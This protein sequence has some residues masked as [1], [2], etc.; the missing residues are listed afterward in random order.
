MNKIKRYFGFGLGLP[1]L[2]Y[3]GPAYNSYGFGKV[4]KTTWDP[5][6]IPVDVTAGT[7]IGERTV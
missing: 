5:R 4:Y 7:P 1:G 2:S 6:S 3:G